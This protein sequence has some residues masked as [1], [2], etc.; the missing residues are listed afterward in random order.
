MPASATGSVQFLTNQVTFGSPVTLAGGS[1][2]SLPITNLPRGTNALTAEYSG[3]DTFL[4]GAVTI[5]EVVT[6]HPPVAGVVNIVRPAGMNVLIALSDLATNWTD[7]DGDSI[8]LAGINPVSSHGVTLLLVNLTTNLNGT[9]VITN[10]AFIGYDNPS[11]INDQ[12]TYSI[13]DGQGG[14]NVGVVN[15]LTSSNALAG[16]AT[17]IRITGDKGVSLD[18]SGLPGYA[19]ALQRSTNLVEWATIWTTNAPSSGL[20]T[21]VDYFGDLGGYSPASAYYRVTWAP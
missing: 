18:F 7:A 10:D 12:I 16:Q 3:D 14:T 19:Y 8:G 6:N 20:F 9:Y 2:T 17:G 4:A 15:F 21:F 11:N 13:D 1:A 5:T